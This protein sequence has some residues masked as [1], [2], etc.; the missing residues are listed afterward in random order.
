MSSLI[1][2]GNIVLI[3]T[4]ITKIVGDGIY[5]LGV[6]DVYLLKRVSQTID[7]AYII[8]SDNPN[9]KH[10]ELSYAT[11]DGLKARGKVIQ[12]ISAKNVS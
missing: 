12:V 2:D 4:S 8:S 3:N 11:I 6:D 10:T 5:I 9:L 7:G 1:N